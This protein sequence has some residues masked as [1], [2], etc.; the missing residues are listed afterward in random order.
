ML[1]PP[2]ALPPFGLLVGINDAQHYKLRKIKQKEMNNIL[3]VYNSNIKRILLSA[4]QLLAKFLKLQKLQKSLDQQCSPASQEKVNKLVKDIIQC[5][6]DAL[7]L[8]SKKCELDTSFK[9]ENDLK[10]Q[11]PPGY[12]PYYSRGERDIVINDIDSTVFGSCAVKATRRSLS[13]FGIDLKEDATENKIV[14]LVKTDIINGGT[15]PDEIQKAY[16]HYGFD[17]RYFEDK[18][19]TIDDIKRITKNGHVINVCVSK[20]SSAHALL[21][22]GIEE[23]E[24]EN[25]YNVILYDPSENR[26]MKVLY[27]ELKIVLDGR[28]TLPSEEQMGT[29]EPLLKAKAVMKILKC[30][31][32]DAMKILKCKNPDKMDI[33][34]IIGKCENLPRKDRIQC[35]AYCFDNLKRRIQQSEGDLKLSDEYKAIKRNIE[36]ALI[37]ALKGKDSLFHRYATFSFAC[38]EERETGEKNLIKNINT[39]AKEWQDQEQDLEQKKLQNGEKEAPKLIEDLKREDENFKNLIDNIDD[40]TR[41]NIIQIYYDYGK[42]NIREGRYQEARDNFTRVIALNEGHSGAFARRGSAYLGLGQLNEAMADLNHALELNDKNIYA[43][44][45]RGVV[46]RKKGRYE[47]AWADFTQV[48]VLGYSEPW[49]EDELEKLRPLMRDNHRVKI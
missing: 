36:S 11:I 6:T 39:L 46:H 15:P 34:F 45:H 40:D 14:K 24:T 44:A 48:C 5:F 47:E 25:G 9:L 1:A 21:I 32:S 20:P 8:T 28:C 37:D 23:T 41:E 38:H 18:V 7:S 42:Y 22:E 12:N 31:N 13:I 33:K 17:Y 29:S 16:Q 43:W 35:Y 27:K 2:Q 19:V 3:D 26:R 10:G 30:K 49:I 4:D